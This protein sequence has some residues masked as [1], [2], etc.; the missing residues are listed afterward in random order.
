MQE[1]GNI[2]YTWDIW[3]LFVIQTCFLNHCLRL[4]RCN[5]LG[6]FKSKKNKLN[7]RL[8][9]KRRNPYHI[10]LLVL[11]LA[12]CI[13]WTPTVS[14]RYQMRYIHLQT[15][16]LGLHNSTD[17]F[18]LLTFYQPKLL[19]ELLGPTGPF[20]VLPGPEIVWGSENDV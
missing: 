2:S 14:T 10:L 7:Y 13:C 4:V 18:G 12:Y 11:F 16:F 19:L 15:Q 1:G 20:L 6:T 17:K 9:H 8:N 5:L 3:H